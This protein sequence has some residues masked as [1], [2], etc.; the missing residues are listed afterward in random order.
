MG[1]SKEQFSRTRFLRRLGVTLAVAV[2]AG[3]LAKPAFAVG[4]C[5]RDC[6]RCVSCG[7]SACYCWCNCS[8]T[9]TGDY[10]WEVP[11]GCLVAQHCIQCPC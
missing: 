5:C 1:D 9:G 11:A 8:G 7:E 6:N 4:N 3:V 10:C 2:G